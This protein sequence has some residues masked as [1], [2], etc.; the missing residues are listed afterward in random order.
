MHRNRKPKIHWAADATALGIIAARSRVKRRA[1]VHPGLA[2]L[3]VGIVVREVTHAAVPVRDTRQAIGI[4]ERVR[5]G[6]IRR[7]CCRC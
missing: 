1:A 5:D 3:P 2:R 6:V 4:V 7:I